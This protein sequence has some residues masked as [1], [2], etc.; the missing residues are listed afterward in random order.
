MSEQGSRFCP[1]C[2]RY[3]SDTDEN[4]MSGSMDLSTF[5]VSVGDRFERIAS[6]KADKCRV[7]QDLDIAAFFDLLHQVRGQGLL[8]RFT[9]NKHGYRGR[10]LERFRAAWPAE[11]PPPTMKTRPV[12]RLAS[13]EPPPYTNPRP[14]SFS[15]LPTLSLPHSP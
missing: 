6:I 2:P 8:Q 5:V 14:N 1:V 3:A 13:L 10:N 4:P 12:Q 15:S 11:F 7:D 9:T